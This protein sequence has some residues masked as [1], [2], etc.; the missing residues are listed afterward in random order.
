MGF[1]EL[2]LGTVVGMPTFGAVIG[3]HN[4]TLMD[5]STF[6]QPS[7]GW[8]RT[9]GK[10]LENDPVYPDVLIINPPEQDGKVPDDQIKEALRVLL[11]E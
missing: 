6:R 4:L 2:N 9:S 7:S 11:K 10:N 1:K 5:G 8:Y 3:T